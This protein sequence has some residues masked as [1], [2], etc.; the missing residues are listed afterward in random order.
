MSRC[1]RVHEALATTT[2]LAAAVKRHVTRAITK[3]AQR[4]ADTA[5]VKCR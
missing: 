5:R 2:A 1:R 4:L 3:D